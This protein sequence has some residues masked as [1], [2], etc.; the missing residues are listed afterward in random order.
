MA[1]ERPDAIV[2]G[3]GPNG[4]SAA[5][6]LARG[7]MQVTVYEGHEQIGGGTRTAA[8]TLPG[9]RH[10]VC[11]AVHPMGASSPVFRDVQV[12]QHGLRWV[13]P[14]VPLAH[15]FDDGT[16][17]VLERSTSATAD[18][19]AAADRDA[20]RRLMDPLVED[21]PALAHDALAPLHVP[22]HP[23]VM[24]R[25]ARRGVRS[26]LG[27]VKS[28]FGNDRARA[29]LAG[30]AAHTLEPLSGLPTAAFGLMLAAA[31]HAVGWP[32]AR[33]GSQAIADALAAVLRDHGGRIVTRSP[34]RSLDDLPPARAT[35]LD[36]TPRQVLAVAGD[37][38]PSRFRRALGRYRYGPGVCKLDW[39]LAEPIPWRAP[40][41]AR[42]GTVHLGGSTEAI[43][44]SAR[45]PWEGRLDPRPFVILAQPTRFDPTR[46][47]AGRHT[48]W[49]YCHVPHASP[50]DMTEAIEAQVERFA[51]GFREIVLA[52]SV[53]TAVTMERDNPNLVGGDINGGSQDW[54]QLFFRPRVAI[55]PYATPVPGLFLCS[56][57]TP[58][59]GSVHGLCGH[60]A[61]RAALRGGAALLAEL[62]LPA[63][64]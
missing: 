6:E 19:L 13:H 60:Y 33:G 18:T 11:S 35:L 46:A 50:A 12:V 53:R 27:L 29:L 44:A 34:V 38:L 26:A 30:I 5:V 7:G 41:C 2:V 40:A 45:A 14:E 51:P 36:L 10:D 17:A 47:P 63:A 52:R 23:I 1:G 15:P 3:S 49:A 61:A 54:R 22:R 21:W 25:F 4:L 64:A 55:D 37:R 9:F 58:P 56:S 32:F 57:S 48:A 8:L 59:G 39:A 24:A 62:S 20:Y 31:G 43:A 28:W 16:A 42:A